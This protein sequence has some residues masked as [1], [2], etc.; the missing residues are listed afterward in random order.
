M[1]DNKQNKF[2][3]FSKDIIPQTDEKLAVARN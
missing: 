2:D 1:Q 3:Y